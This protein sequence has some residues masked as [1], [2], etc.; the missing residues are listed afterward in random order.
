M[1][2]K[3]D[4]LKEIKRSAKENGEI[5]LGFKRFG[6]VTGIKPYDWHKYWARFGDAQREAG[7]A[8]NTLQGAYEEN[9]LFEK[10]ILLAR[11]LHK[12]P[13]AQELRVKQSSDVDFP[14]SKT[15]FRWGTQ[16]NLA[17]KLLQYATV[18]KYKD[19]IELCH[20]YLE[21]IESKKSQSQDN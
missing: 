12:F 16:E 19:I 7:F 8:P 1:F 18:K 10:F 13:T 3:D 21:K 17:T 2:S 6:D 20:T 4:I 9:Y 15:F 14:S 5:P 11:E